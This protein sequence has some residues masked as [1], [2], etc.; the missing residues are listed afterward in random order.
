MKN[1]VME[2][3]NKEYEY[4]QNINL[5]LTYQELLLMMK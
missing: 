1:K 2:L 5:N 3:T 4:L